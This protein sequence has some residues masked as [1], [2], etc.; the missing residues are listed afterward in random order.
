MKN[1]ILLT[2]KTMCH[3]CKLNGFYCY[4][5][6]G[7]DY[8]TCPLCKNNDFFNGIAEYDEFYYLH[9]KYFNNYDNI[10]KIDEIYQKNLF[11]SNCKIIFDIGCVHG[12]NGCTDDCYNGHFIG[13]YKYNSIEY[14][15]MPCFDSIEEWYNEIKNIEILEWICPNDNT[16][17]CCKATYPINTH[18]KSYNKCKL[19]R[20]II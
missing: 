2:K 6:R 19:Q 9:K 12:C 15:G 18:P 11:C 8:Y 10:D 17:F 20:N 5:P 4:T 13:R 7:A 3:E 14:I 1:I 16:L